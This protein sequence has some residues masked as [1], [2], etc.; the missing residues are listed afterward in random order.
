M[1]DVERA[2]VESMLRMRPNKKI[3]QAEL[4]KDTAKY[5]ML[6]DIHNMQTRISPKS[7]ADALLAEMR[8]VPG[9]QN[10]LSVSC[11]YRVSFDNGLA[12]MFGQTKG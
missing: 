8:N 11:V 10:I 6:K 2:A 7:D 9:K 5:V 1:N 3:L 4:L 12:I